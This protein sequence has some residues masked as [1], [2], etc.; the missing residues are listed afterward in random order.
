MVGMAADKLNSPSL[1]IEAWERLWRLGDG[2]E[3]AS[4]ELTDIYR[5]AERWDRLAEFLLQEGRHGAQHHVVRAP[6]T[7]RHDEPDRLGGVGL[8][9]G[10]TAERQGGDGR[11]GA[12]NES[13]FAG[14]H[15]DLLK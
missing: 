2:V 1:V 4:R 13:M 6:C 10:Q 5:R 7:G 15:G 12:R 9:C 3:E 11:A 8:G 14:W